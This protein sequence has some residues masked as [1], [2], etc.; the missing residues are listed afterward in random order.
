MT[1]TEAIYI[2]ICF[3]FVLLCFRKAFRLDS[4]KAIPL[5]LNFTIFASA[6]CICLQYLATRLSW[7]K[8]EMHILAGRTWDELRWDGMAWH[9]TERDDCVYIAA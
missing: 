8:E 5:L 7:R 4:G 1:A 3:V 9:G 6:H 2:A